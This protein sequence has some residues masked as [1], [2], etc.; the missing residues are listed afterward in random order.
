MSKYYGTYNY[1][2]KYLSNTPCCNL[3]G[4]GQ[5]GPQGEQGASSIGPVGP[6]GSSGVIYVGPTGKG[7][8]GYTG[9]PANPNSSLTGYTGPTGPSKFWDP[10]G[11][12]AIVYNG[13]VYVNGE[14]DVSDGVITTQIPYGVRYNFYTGIL[15]PPTVFVDYT[16]MY[17]IILCDNGVTE[18]RLSLIDLFI[19]NGDWVIITNI[20]SSPINVISGLSTIIYTIPA[21]SSTTPSSI[22]CTYNTSS[23]SWIC[24]FY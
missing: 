7:C 14:L 17:Q 19:K 21:L 18:V 11:S 22:K 9:P 12:N 20:S 2:N 6:T 8:P 15:I 3:N 1:Y 10:L 24:G 4:Q 16:H 23:N 5:Q 13:P